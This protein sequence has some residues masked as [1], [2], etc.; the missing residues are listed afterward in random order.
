VTAVHAGN[1]AGPLLNVEDLR[2]T[3]ASSS[4]E[5]VSGVSFSVERGAVLGLVGESGSG[6]TTAALAVLGYARRGL[7]IS[8]GTVAFGGRDVLRMS[9]SELRDLRGRA[10]AYVAQDPSS[11]LNPALKVGYQLAEV[12]KIHKSSDP[13]RDRAAR[14]REMLREVRLDTTDSVLN[15]YPHQLS[16]GQQQRIMIAMA[17]ACRPAVIVLDEPTTGLDVTTQRHVLDTVRDLCRSY[18][19]GAIYVSH[20]LAVVADIADHVAV[21]YSGAVV[22]LGETS[23][24]MVRPAHPYTRALL[25]AV[26]SAD[27]RRELSGIGGRPPAPGQRPSGC[28]FAPRCP[29]AVAECAAEIPLADLGS[30]HVARCIRLATAAAA[31]E[32]TESS[33][34][35]FASDETAARD[36]VALEVRN[37]HASY[38]LKQ[39]LNGVA[40]SVARRSCFAVVGESGSGKTTLARCIVGM[41]TQW[42]GEVVI[43]G[44]AVRPGVARRS[45]DDVRRT[46]YIFQNPYGAL[47]PRRTIGALL[48]QPL[49]HFFD[50]GWQERRDRIV[51]AL[52]AVSLG[53]DFVERYP[54]ALSGGE[55]QRVAIARALVAE[56]DV[57][58]CDEITSAL[59]VSVQAYVVNLLRDLQVSRGLT[60]LFITHNLALVRTIA[61][62][63]AVMSDGR[64]VET[65]RTLDVL[66]NPTDD[67]TIELLA[68]AP[69]IALPDNPVDSR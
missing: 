39:V 13:G 29:Y 50:L 38:G 31:A 63:V 28:M 53:A 54:P 24:V 7:Q 25:A 27:R 66:D 17:F 26:P 33:G 5:I 60:L 47:N 12:L 42:S 22:E 61:D 37:L 16:G 58:V 48:D 68:N 23:A 57:L 64:I 59:D 46:Q 9:P 14:M 43:G 65:G 11:A 35:G 36:D 6:K 8:S 40:I 49:Q 41:H 1:G 51:S 18:G 15:A 55:R 10:I 52:E 3:L 32:H 67:Y 45:T 4:V 20:D 21:M 44:R 19:T 69:S 30:G 34:D 56:P 62:E 2:V